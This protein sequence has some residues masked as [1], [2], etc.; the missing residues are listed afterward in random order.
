MADAV[1]RIE[2][3]LRPRAFPE[4][5]MSAPRRH[6]IRNDPTALVGS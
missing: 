5:R 3:R 1:D 4:E 2:A 6:D